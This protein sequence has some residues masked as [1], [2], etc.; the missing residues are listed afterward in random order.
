MIWSMQRAGESF[1]CNKYFSTVVTLACGFI[2]TKIG[3]SNI[4]PLFGSANQLLSALVLI[5]LCV[6]LKV[7]GKRTNAFTL[8]IMLSIYFY[9]TG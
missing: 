8:I 5:T 7:T 2:L 9:R 6:F 1:L 4:W 3:Y